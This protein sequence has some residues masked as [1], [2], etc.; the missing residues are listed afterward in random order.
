V[1]GDIQTSFSVRLAAVD[2]MMVTWCDAPPSCENASNSLHLTGGGVGT[3]GRHATRRGEIDLLLEIQDRF[4]YSSFSDMEQGE[5]VV[6][7]AVADERGYQGRI[8]CPNVTNG[9]GIGALTVSATG[10]FTAAFR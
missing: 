7:I 6:T 8:S 1:T 3:L 10:T 2:P 5:C 9:W 4:L